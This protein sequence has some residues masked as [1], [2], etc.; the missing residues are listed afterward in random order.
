M[1]RIMLILLLLVAVPANAPADQSEQTEDLFWKIVSCK[2]STQIQHYLQA[3]PK[4][5]YVEKAKTCLAQ[6]TADQSGQTEDLFWGSVS[7][8]DSTQV[9]LYL[10]AYPEGRYVERA[11][12]CLAQADIYRLIQGL[13]K[14]VGTLEQHRHSPFRGYYCNYCNYCN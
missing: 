3:Y 11:K 1:C 7:C 8:K 4:G 10:H 9:L 14:R 13:E 5:R 6:A 2:D 12:V